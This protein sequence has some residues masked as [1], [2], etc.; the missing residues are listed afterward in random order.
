ME[1]KI[2]TGTTLLEYATRPAIL[3]NH[4]NKYRIRI[5]GIGFI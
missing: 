2:V 3:S 5:R 1:E 4:T